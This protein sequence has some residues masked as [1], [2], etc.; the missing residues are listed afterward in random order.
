MD[1][2]RSSSMASFQVSRHGSFPRFGL[3]GFGN[4]NAYF[5]SL[6]SVARTSPR[7]VTVVSICSLEWE[8]DTWKRSR[9]VPSGTT[10]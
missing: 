8:S 7:Q 5:L 4:S 1:F 6:Y 2:E 9:A 10:G 3:A